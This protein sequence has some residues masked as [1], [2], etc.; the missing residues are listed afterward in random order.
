MV[1]G[2][3]G[4]HPPATVSMTQGDKF[5][6]DSEN[7]VGISDEVITAVIMGTGFEQVARVKEAE[8][9]SVK[10]CII[11]FG[12]ELDEVPEMYKKRSPTT[13]L[14]EKTPPILVIDGELDRPGQ[15]YVEFREKLDSRGEE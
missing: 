3:A 12:G 9:G 13:H 7:Y 2:S 8:G 1:E 15:R 14:A 10:T 4:G 6:T 5:F 11:F